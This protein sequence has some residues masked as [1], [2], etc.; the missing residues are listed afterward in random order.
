M[1]FLVDMNLAPDWCPFL[2]GLG[3]DAVH[4]STVGR[5]SEPDRELFDFARKEGRVV[6]SHDLDFSAILAATGATGPSVVQVRVHAPTVAAIGNHVARA[7]SRYE[8]ELALGAVM[9]LDFRSARVRL[10]PLRSQ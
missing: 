3:H 4:W 9:S 7:V 10:L 5:G 6:L 2:A 1:R 8:R